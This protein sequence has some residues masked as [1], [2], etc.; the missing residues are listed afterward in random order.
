MVTWVT[1]NVSGN[2]QW[3]SELKY[4]LGIKRIELNKAIEVGKEGMEIMYLCA[5]SGGLVVPFSTVGIRNIV[6]IYYFWDFHHISSRNI[7]QMDSWMKKYAT[8]MGDNGSRY[9]WEIPVF[10]TISSN[11]I[12][13]NLIEKIMDK[14]K[15]TV[16]R[17]NPWKT[18]IYRIKNRRKI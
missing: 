4:M 18:S 2:Q 11:G 8:K 12:C 7:Y 16:P 1:I 3:W 10:N 5:E 13:S 14:T 6:W 15:R 17:I 9:I